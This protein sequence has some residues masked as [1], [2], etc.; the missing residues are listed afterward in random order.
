M[1]FLKVALQ[2]CFC[3]GDSVDERA[4]AQNLYR[5]A[6]RAHWCIVRIKSRAKDDIDKFVAEYWLAPA[7]MSQ[8]TLDVKGWEP[9]SFGGEASS[10]YT[11]DLTITTEHLEHALLLKGA[12]IVGKQRAIEVLENEWVEY[13]NNV[14]MNMSDVCRDI[15]L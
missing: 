2:G 11:Y 12:Q 9:F 13:I 15:F 6:R 14:N 3:T 7:A 5:T 8:W 10:K 4:R 1:E